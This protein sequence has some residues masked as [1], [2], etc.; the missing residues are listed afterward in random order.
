VPLALSRYEEGATVP[1]T[2]ELPDHG[3]TEES[4]FIS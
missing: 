4:V 2:I 3:M 1:L